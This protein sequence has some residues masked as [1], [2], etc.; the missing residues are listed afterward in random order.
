MPQCLNDS[1][2]P[3]FDSRQVRVGFVV[4]IVTLGLHSVP[5][6]PLLSVIV[7]PQMLQLIHI[8]ITNAI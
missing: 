6:F 4:D 5:V 1:I 3:E 7:I 8:Y 2:R